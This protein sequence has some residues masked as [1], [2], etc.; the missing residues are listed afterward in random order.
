MG[1]GVGGVG[2]KVGLFGYELGMGRG[3]NLGN[4]KWGVGT[5]GYIAPN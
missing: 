2:S 3:G 5:F 1:G 4:K